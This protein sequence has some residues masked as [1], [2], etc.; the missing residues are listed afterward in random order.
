ME[1]ETGGV[2]VRI[3]GRLRGRG[4]NKV[5]VRVR[6]RVRVQPCNAHLISDLTRVCGVRVTVR[7]RFRCF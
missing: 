4:R 1:A 6:V 5:R 2:K 7:V 3:R